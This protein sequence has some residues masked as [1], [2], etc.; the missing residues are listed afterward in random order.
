M[1]ETT[2]LQLFWVVFFIKLYP[3]NT[4]KWVYNCTS[5]FYRH[6]RYQLCQ[7]MARICFLLYMEAE[8]SFVCARLE[9]TSTCSRRNSSK[10]S[11]RTTWVSVSC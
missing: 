9:T 4:Q 6:K 2:A 3:L 5:D 7:Q 10:M 8:F 11:W 1:E